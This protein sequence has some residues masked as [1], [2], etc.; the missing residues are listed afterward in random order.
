MSGRLRDK[1]WKYK[2][3][4][5]KRKLKV[6]KEQSDELKNKSLFKCLRKGIND[7]A[8]GCDKGRSHNY[9][10]NE[11]KKQYVNECVDDTGRSQIKKISESEKKVQN[12]GTQQIQY[13]KR[14]IDHVQIN[15]DIY[16]DPGNL[17]QSITDNNL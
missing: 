5:D 4:A 15:Q 8:V 13:D 11:S 2:N 17:L 12:E 16:D 14:N 1:Y 3:G 10:E 6:I 7:C 9:S